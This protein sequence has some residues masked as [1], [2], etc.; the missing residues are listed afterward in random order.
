[1]G[2]K[3]ETFILF[4]GDSI[5]DCGRDRSAF[6]NL[7][8]GYP[9]IVAEALG[10]L[11]PDLALSFANRGISGDRT[12]DALARWETDCIEL[13]PSLVSI[14][15]GINDVWHRSSGHGLPIEETEENYRKI[16]ARTREALGDIP[17]LILSPFL[18][19]DHTTEMK[20]EDVEAAAA[21]SKRLAKEFGC[22]YVPLNTLLEKASEALPP[23][24]LT[25]E[26]VHPT[27]R[28]HSVIAKHWLDAALPLL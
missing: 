9:R 2:L 16:L 15:L 22:V 13:R 21:V 8:G 10:V 20:Q 5:T 11:R 7:G 23:L 6:E 27:D 4:Q 14:L 12:V 1:M 24:T 17:I 26:G 19:P 3:K 28:G 25:E 18:T